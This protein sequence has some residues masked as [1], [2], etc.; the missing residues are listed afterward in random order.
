MRILSLVFSFLV[1]VSLVTVALTY[2]E[3]RVGQ[4]RIYVQDDWL[5]SSDQKSYQDSGYLGN[6]NPGHGSDRYG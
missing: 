5:S 4:H 1:T 6:I 2:L 3:R